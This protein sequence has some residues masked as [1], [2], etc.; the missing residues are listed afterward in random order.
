MSLHYHRKEPCGTPASIPQGAGISQSIETLDFLSERTELINRITLA[1]KLQLAHACHV[2][3]KVVSISKNTAPVGKLLT[4]VQGH[5][6][7]K[8]HA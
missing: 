7:R 5:V 1:E 4:E 6:V 3:S 8:P 2:V